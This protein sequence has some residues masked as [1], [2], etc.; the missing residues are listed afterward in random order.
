MMVENLEIRF[1]E[2]ILILRVYCLYCVLNRT[3][4]IPNW[5][6]EPCLCESSFITANRH[7]VGV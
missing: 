2:Q 4:T 1:E 7:I 6:R 5:D 3:D